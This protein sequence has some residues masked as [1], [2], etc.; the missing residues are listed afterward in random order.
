[1]GMK[2]RISQKALERQDMLDQLTPEQRADWQKMIDYREKA[3]KERD[4]KLAEHLNTFN[5]GVIAIIITIIV[6][7]IAAPVKSADYPDFAKQIF[8]YLLSFFVVA[9]FWF[10]IHK[11]FS[12]FISKASK[13]TMIADFCFLASLSLMPVMT[14]WLMA[15]LSVMSVVN[16]GIVY[17]LVQ[18]FELLTEL[19]GIRRAIRH[20]QIY[21]ILIGRYAWTRLIW[22]FALNL[23][24]IG[25]SFFSPR[26][27]MVLYLAFPIINFMFPERRRD[28]RKSK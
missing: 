6:L 20:L 1:M 14:K 8:I 19:S 3:L 10:Q 15:D 17:F 24:F 23:V 11:T 25:I 2:N 18:S 28:T 21:R 4:S 22:L 9:N 7:E 16:F 26:V 27:G 12:F 5:D 13:L